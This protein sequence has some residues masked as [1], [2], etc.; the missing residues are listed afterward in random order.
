MPL[1]EFIDETIKVLGTDAEEV[2]V[3]RAKPMRNN[4]GP[5]EGAFVTQ[6]NDMMLQ[7]PA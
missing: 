5:E 7:P 1:A 2:L 6:F 3:E 4:V